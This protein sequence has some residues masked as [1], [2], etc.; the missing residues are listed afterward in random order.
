MITGHAPT[1]SQVK[2]MRRSKRLEPCGRCQTSTAVRVALPCGRLVSLCVPCASVF[3]RFLNKRIRDL[4]RSVPS[5]ARLSQSWSPGN[6]PES[7]A[8]DSLHSFQGF[9]GNIARKAKSQRLRPDRKVDSPERKVDAGAEDANLWQREESFASTL[10]ARAAEKNAFSAQRSPR[11]P[12]GAAVGGRGTGGERQHD[13]AFQPRK[14][15][16]MT[17]SNS[18]PGTR[19][20]GS[21]SIG[22]GRDDSSE[23]DG[24]EGMSR[25][26]SGLGMFPEILSPAGG[27]SARAC[28][29]PLNGRVSPLGTSPLGTSPKSSVKVRFGLPRP[30]RQDNVDRHAFVGGGTSVASLAMVA[31]G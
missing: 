19:R 9:S 22:P 6:S 29:S 10:C 12:R 26:N 4:A 25:K 31:R 23:T 30:E 18:R 17:I 15:S 20:L 13:A 24:P 3:A 11:T 28:A 1:E 16:P 14:G 8:K 5:E 7:L 21:R 2:T 27:V